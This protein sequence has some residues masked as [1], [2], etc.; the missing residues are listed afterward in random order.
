MKLV[1]LLLITFT[2]LSLSFSNPFVGLAT[3]LM[4]SDGAP[5]TNNQQGAI[6]FTCGYRWLPKKARQ[7]YV[8]L[9]TATFSNWENC[10]RCV[11]I[12]CVDKLCKNSKYVTA[13]VG[14]D[15]F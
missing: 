3:E 11:I 15:E 1:Y 8:S 6:N 10:G 7:Y 2:L 13:M 14:N 12:K 5:F 4:G 9:N